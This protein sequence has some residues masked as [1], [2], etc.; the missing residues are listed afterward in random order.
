LPGFLSTTLTLSTRTEVVPPN[1][2]EEYGKIRQEVWRDST[3][4]LLLPLGYA[5]PASRHDFGELP[6]RSNAAPTPQ[7][8]SGPPSAAPR[9]VAQAPPSS[10]NPGGQ[11]PS[12]E[13]PSTDSQAV[14]EKRS[15]AAESPA[16]DVG[17]VRRRRTALPAW[18]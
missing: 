6:P 18:R 1:R 2:L 16:P 5:R 11:A 17:P 3:R 12:L 8:P 7:T 13:T 9:A 10:A 15:M 14:R 4:Q